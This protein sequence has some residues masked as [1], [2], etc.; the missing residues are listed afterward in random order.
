MY[1]A[2]RNQGVSNMAGLFGSSTNVT[3]GDQTD[4]TDADEGGDELSAPPLPVEKSR[5]D[6]GDYDHGDGEC[7]N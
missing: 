1:V 6:Q 2:I 5:P 7:R 3:E 4:D